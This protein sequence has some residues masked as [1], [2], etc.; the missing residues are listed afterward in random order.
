MCIKLR[1]KKKKKNTITMSYLKNHLKNKLNKFSVSKPS[2]LYI[3]GS[4]LGSNYLSNSCMN[5]SYI[6]KRISHEIETM[7]KTASALG[8][9]SLSSNQIFNFDSIFIIHKDPKQL[10]YHKKTT[11]SDYLAIINPKITHIKKNLNKMSEL[12]PSFPFL[13][14]NVMRFNEISVNYFNE[15][16]EEVTEILRDFPARVF[17]HE[18]DHINGIMMIDWRVSQGEIEILE[19][20]K[21][22]Y[23]EFDKVLGKYKR[24]IADIKKSHPEIF[25]YYENEANYG[26]SLEKNGEIWC[27]FHLETFRK[28]KA[29]SKEEEILSELE[30]VAVLALEKTMVVFF[31]FFCCRYI[32]NKYFVFSLYIHILILVFFNYFFRQICKKMKMIFY[33]MQRKLLVMEL[34]KGFK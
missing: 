27:E 13:Q 14:A 10:W 7:K 32:I 23:E 3:Y 33:R 8:L 34:V 4:S 6:S 1:H 24:I 11:P 20:A 31:Y 22:D 17:Q 18:F 16:F 5:I 30:N 29:W 19:T 9:C 28:Q 12:C 25:D 26:K 2:A 15:N 21:Q